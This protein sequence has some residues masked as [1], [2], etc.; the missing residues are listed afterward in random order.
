MQRQII[1]EAA[2]NNGKRRN[3]YREIWQK[4][5]GTAAK[6]NGKRSDN[7]WESLG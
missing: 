2:T 5:M 7:Y 6:N 3:E 4:I 1:G